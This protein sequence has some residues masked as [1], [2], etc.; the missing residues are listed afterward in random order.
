MLM[1]FFGV[2]S[3][4]F[5]LLLTASA[6]LSAGTSAWASSTDAWEA[7][8]KASAKACIAASGFREASVLP[9]V[10]FSDVT[11]YDARVVSGVYPQAHMKGASGK[12]LC[13]YNRKTR[14]VEVQEIAK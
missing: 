4:K 7:L 11:A 6:L 1:I 3:M 8:D 2:Y 12:M 13:L 5:K 10:H 9:S 14:Q